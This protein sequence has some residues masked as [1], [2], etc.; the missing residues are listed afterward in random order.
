MIL[1]LEEMLEDM[2]EENVILLNNSVLKCLVNIVV[3]AH[4]LLQAMMGSE[5][6]AAFEVNYRLNRNVSPAMSCLRIVIDGLLKTDKLDM[7]L[8]LFKD[9][10]HLGCKPDVLI[11]NNLIDGLCQID[12]RKVTSS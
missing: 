6:D 2:S 11:Y 4:F 7:A 9:M 10:I 1:L 12:W 8:C 5:S 3:K